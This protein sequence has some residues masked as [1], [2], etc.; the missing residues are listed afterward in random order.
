MIESF[1]PALKMLIDTQLLSFQ[2]HL[3]SNVCNFPWNYGQCA[4]ISIIRLFVFQKLWSVAALIEEE[5]WTCDS[6]IQ[7]YLVQIHLSLNY[8]DS[9]FLC[10][11]GVLRITC[12][13]LEKTM[14]ANQFRTANSQLETLC[15]HCCS[16]SP[17]YYDDFGFSEILPSLKLLKIRLLMSFKNFVFFNLSSNPK[18]G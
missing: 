1:A 12:S 3:S 6:L 11:K 2:I 14:Q 17:F 16:F 10:R 9:R 4:D 15:W 5:F 8:F 13:Y 18:S 7:F